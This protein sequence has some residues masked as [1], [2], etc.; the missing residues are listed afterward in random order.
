MAEGLESVYSH[1]IRSL[2]SPIGHLLDDE[3]VSEVM[4]NGHQEIY[5]ERKGR[6]EKTDA[7][8]D[9]EAELASAMRNVAQ[10]VGKTLDAENPSIEARLPDG[11]RVHIVQAPAARKGICVAIRK[12]SKSKLGLDDLVKFGAL[13][14]E[15][16]EFFAVCVA[17]AKNIIVSGGTG[18][19]KTTLL[20]CLS[21]LIPD[22]DR[23]LVLEDS[24]ELQLAQEHVVP[25]EVKQPDRHGRGGMT[26]RDLFKASLRMRPDRIVVGEC[27]GGEALDMVQAMTSGHGGSMSTLHANTPADAL[28]RL[29]TMCLMAGVDLPLYALRSQVA[30]AMHVIVQ[31][32]RFHDG[33]RKLTHIS[34]VLPLTDEGKYEVVDIFRLE[35]E[36]SERRM[37]WTGN[38]PTFAEE[39]YVSGEGVELINLTKKMWKERK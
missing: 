20:N 7:R 12:F 36:L 3:S 8:F 27:R 14:E 10:F 4:I 16:A 15:A 18:S 6:L 38:Y 39:P 13:S 21:A 29:E 26:I 34:E 25:F 22:T 28:N 31:I 24:S 17:M 35:G 9:D 1:T 5:V 11:S 23:V 19:G 33:S 30:S 2:L 37:Q 32:S